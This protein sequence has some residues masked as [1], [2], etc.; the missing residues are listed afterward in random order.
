MKCNEFLLSVR[1]RGIIAA[2]DDDAHALRGD[3]R[4]VLLCF[5]CD[6][7]QPIEAEHRI[8]RRAIKILGENNLRAEVLIKNGALAVRDFDLMAQHDVEFGTTIVSA[9]DLWRPTSGR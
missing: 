3:P 9:S 1:R 7:Y 4:P 2:P 8:T 5:T 6:P